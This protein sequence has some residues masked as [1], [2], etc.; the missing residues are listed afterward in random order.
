M[1]LISSLDVPCTKPPFPITS[2]TMLPQAF[3]GALTVR[4]YG[5]PANG[6]AHV[7]AATWLTEAG[8]ALLPLANA[9]LEAAAEAARAVSDLRQ[10]HTGRVSLAA[11]QT[12]GTYVMPRL[13]AAFQIRN[14]G[15]RPPAAPL[16]LR[17]SAQALHCWPA[18]LCA[19]QPPQIS[20]R[21]SV[22]KWTGIFALDYALTGAWGR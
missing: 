21:L 6:A 10:A 1:S 7:G 9:I 3:G 20:S 19:N 5:R 16:R 15:V 17:C 13:L 2:D 12:V 18:L 22:L 4:P 14:P 8:Q 11:S